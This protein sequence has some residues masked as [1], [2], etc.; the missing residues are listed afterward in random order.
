MNELTK[1]ELEAAR[2]FLRQCEK[3]LA[4]V[5]GMFLGGGYVEGARRLNDAL[6]QIG[7][8]ARAIEKLLAGQ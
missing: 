2:D 5:R 1:A 6:G 4:A 7:D 3:M 8:E